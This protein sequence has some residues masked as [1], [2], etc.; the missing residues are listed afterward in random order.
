MKSE[1]GEEAWSQVAERST[2]LLGAGVLLHGLADVAWVPFVI[3][4]RA[5]D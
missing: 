3:I 4:H 2:G 1:L 5:T